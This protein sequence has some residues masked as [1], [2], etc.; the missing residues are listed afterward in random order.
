MIELRKYSDGSLLI[1]T[2]QDILVLT[3]RQ[4]KQLEEYLVKKINEKKIDEEEQPTTL[5][6]EIINRYEGVKNNE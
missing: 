3:S 4:T 5:A 1:E 2:I 6:T